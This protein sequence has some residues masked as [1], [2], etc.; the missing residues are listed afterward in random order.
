LLSSGKER[1]REGEREREI[2]EIEICGERERERQSLFFLSGQ[3][4][5]R[6]CHIYRE[7]VTG[8]AGKARIHTASM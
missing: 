4:P 6:L 5:G 3:E 1:E 7:V 8:I 2:L